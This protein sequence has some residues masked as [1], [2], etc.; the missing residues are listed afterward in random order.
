MDCIMYNVYIVYDEKYIYYVRCCYLLCC[1]VLWTR[2]LLSHSY[3][4]LEEKLF[5][6]AVHTVTG[7]ILCH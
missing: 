6:L 3:G 5:D 7:K 2:H 1:V 4:L